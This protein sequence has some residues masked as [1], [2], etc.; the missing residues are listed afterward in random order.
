MHD[1]RLSFIWKAF[2][3]NNGKTTENP[4][5]NSTGEFKSMCEKCLNKSSRVK[6]YVLA[7]VRIVTTVD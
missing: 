2:F 4:S 6:A 5:Y 7:I 1:L 3:P